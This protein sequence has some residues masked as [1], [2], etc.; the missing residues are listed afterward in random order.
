ME[1]LVKFLVEHWILTSVF[2]VISLLLLI[3]EWRQR[4]HG[5]KGLSVAQVV[6]LINH[7]GAVVLD[8]RALDVFKKGHIVNAINLPKAEIASRVN[9]ISKYKKKPV[10]LV[11]H[12][13]LESP[14]VADD[15]LKQGFENL[16][17]LSGGI[18][19][20]KSNAMPVVTK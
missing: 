14:K 6:D 9:Q 2:I 18:E 20:W 7:S 16:S 5:L 13:G 17:Y 15:L 8:V 1:S 12:A 3:H 19:A 10:V 11:C 4:A